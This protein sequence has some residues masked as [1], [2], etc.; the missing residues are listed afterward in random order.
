MNK[1]PQRPLN[2]SGLMKSLAVGSLPAAP[3]R[4][5]T[6]GE[7]IA[8]TGAPKHIVDAPPVPGQRSRI[9]PSHEAFTGVGQ[10]ALDDEKELPLKSHAKEPPLHPATP[11]RVAAKVHPVA[12]DPNVIL[13]DAASLGRAL[14]GQKA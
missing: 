11:A 8:R 4:T 9:G 14:A 3:A 5:R 1:N 10:T 12:N 13:K 7:G 6:E 2:S